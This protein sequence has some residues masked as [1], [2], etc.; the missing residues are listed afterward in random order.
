[1]KAW[2][3]LLISEFVFS[4]QIWSFIPFIL[5][6]KTSQEIVIMRGRE[7]EENCDPK[8]KKKTHTKKFLPYNIEYQ[9]Q[10]STSDL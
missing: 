2:V 9:E 4:F 10:A 8:K 5:A 7:G 3:H 6:D 1:M